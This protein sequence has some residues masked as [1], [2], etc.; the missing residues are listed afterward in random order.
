MP[1]QRLQSDLVSELE[2]N[3]Q[4]KQQWVK[5]KTAFVA[6]AGFFLISPAA[7]SQSF[8]ASPAN[9]DY[10]LTGLGR[11]PES[12]GK[13]QGIPGTI[14]GW[15][16]YAA[17]GTREKALSRS[18]NKEVLQELQAIAVE[19]ELCYFFITLSWIGRC[20]WPTNLL[21]SHNHYRVE[22][23]SMIISR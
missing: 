3:R 6:A 18:L 16:D 20:R 8:S 9:P 2:V 4:L 11:D 1:Q 7:Y 10:D 12:C 14:T 22:R 5:S 13:F 17:S 23:L 21:P 19:K 15:F